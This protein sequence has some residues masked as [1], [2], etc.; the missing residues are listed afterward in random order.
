MNIGIAEVTLATFLVTGYLI[1]T[2]KPSI[3]LQELNNKINKSVIYSE[4]DDWKIIDGMGDCK[5]ITAM[6][7]AELIKQGAI[8]SDVYI[9]IG[10]YMGKSHSTII[11][12]GLYLDNIQTDVKGTFKG[13]DILFKWNQDGIYF[14]DKKVTNESTKL[15]QLIED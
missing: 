13:F 14:D 11:Y 9:A 6:K 15:M 3:D 12:N 10:D 8:P 5:G 7:Y 2:A 4:R 1:A